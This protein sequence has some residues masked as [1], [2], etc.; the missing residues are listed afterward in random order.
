VARLYQ[1]LSEAKKKSGEKV[2]GNLD[3]FA[4]FVQKK[5][6]ELRR[7]YGCNSV[8]Y[9]VEMKDGQVKLKAKAKS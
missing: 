8:I 3:S 7:Q 6:V 4:A 5:T 9:S 2:S 1:A